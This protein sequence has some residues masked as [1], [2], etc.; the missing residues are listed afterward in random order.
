MKSE[1][2]RSLNHFY[3]SLWETAEDAFAAGTIKIDPHLN[4]KSK[5][6]RRGLT[7]ALRP[8]PT[9]IREVSACVDELRQLEPHQYY[10]H[11]AEYHVTVLSLLTCSTLY[12]RSAE[13]DESYGRAMAA[14]V[15]GMS[16]F[17]ILFQGITATP[18][19]VMIQGF[20]EE[21]LLNRLR[22]RLIEKLAGARMSAQ[23]RYAPKAAHMTVM[24]YRRE[25]GNL[26]ALAQKL[27]SLRTRVFGTTRVSALHLVENDWY[28]SSDKLR[29]IREYELPWAGRSRR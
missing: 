12:Q 14:A 25:S 22:N 26:P 18:E 3:D 28:M 1:I 5:D 20:P 16:A 23:Q 15:E 21:D 7:I 19:A 17:G 2:P 13:Q 10:Y 24:R 11:P 8:E 9:T 4:H 6:H 27:R 29:L